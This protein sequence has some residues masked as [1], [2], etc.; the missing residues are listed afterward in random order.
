MG[1]RGAHARKPQRMLRNR[2]DRHGNASDPASIALSAFLRKPADHQ[3]HSRRQENAAAAGPASVCRGRLWPVVEGWPARD[4]NR[5][6]ERAEGQRQNRACWPAWRSATCSAL[7][8]RS[9]GEVYQLR[10]YKLQAAL[11]FAEMRA[12]IEAVPEFDATLQP[13]ALRQGDR[14][15]VRR[16]R[17]LDLRKLE[18]RR[19]ARARASP[20]FW[21]FD[22]FAQS[23][24]ADLLNNLRTAMGKRSRKSGRHHLD[25]SG[26]RSAPALVR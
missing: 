10:Y 14:G 17:R 6:Q 8:A 3:R 5:D 25:A 15:A 26:Q 19:Q 16:R 21:I 1:L 22:E 18:R 13:A 11:I 4:Q 12:I 20:S 2:C 9:R 7:N 23:P 24:N